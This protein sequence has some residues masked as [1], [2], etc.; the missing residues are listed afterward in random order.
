MTGLGIVAA[1]FGVNDLGNRK[2]LEARALW[3]KCGGSELGA[4]YLS[5]PLQE[6]SQIAPRPGR[7]LIFDV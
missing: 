2:S 5:N 1:M 7:P 6:N 3:M 4:G